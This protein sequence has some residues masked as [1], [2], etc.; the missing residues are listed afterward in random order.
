VRLPGVSGLE[1]HR[2]LAHSGSDFPVIFITGHGDI[3]MTVRAMKAG[4]VDFLTKPVNE[5]DL[6]DA[7]QQAIERHAAALSEQVAEQ[8]IQ[9]R[10]STLTQREEQVLELVVR[11]MIIKQIARELGVAEKT[12]K[13]LR[14]RMM[15]KMQADSLADLIRM[16]A[17][18]GIVV[19]DRAPRSE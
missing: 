8:E 17:Q 15:E 1:L 18:V 4:A 19:A 16:A 13:V 11:G 12:I 7:V 14:G 2:L 3:P 9:Q 10:I 6:L 5:Q